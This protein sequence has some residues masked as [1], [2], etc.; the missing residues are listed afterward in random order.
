M[1]GGY[2]AGLPP[3]QGDNWTRY[4]HN[5]AFY[6]DPRISAYIRPPSTSMR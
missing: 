4:Y 6:S 5:G 3:D 1:Y 2:Y